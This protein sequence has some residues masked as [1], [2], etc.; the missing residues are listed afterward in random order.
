[1]VGLDIIL[2]HFAVKHNLWIWE[3]S[4]YPEIINFVGWFIIALADALLY[5]SA[6]L[7]IAR[8]KWLFIIFCVTFLFD[9]RCCLW[10]LFYLSYQQSQLFFEPYPMYSPAETCALLLSYER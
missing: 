7:I 5:I 10:Y 9:F 2:E 6:L 1:M 3:D 4:H 8:I